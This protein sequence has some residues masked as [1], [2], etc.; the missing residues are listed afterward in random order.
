MKNSTKTRIAVSFGLSFIGVLLVY[1]W[2][3][4]PIKQDRLLFMPGSQQGTVNLESATRCDN[5]HGGYNKAVEPAHNWRGGMMAQAARD[6]MWAAC[7]TVALQ[8]S[9]WAL[10]NPNAGDLCIRCHTPTGWLAGHSDPPNLTALAGSDFEGVSCDA[11]HKMVDPFRGL[12][13]TRDVPAETAGTTAASEAL[14]TYTQDYNV[15]AVLQLF[16]ATL[17]F[18]AGTDLPRYYGD[19][20]LPNYIESASGQYFIDASTPKRGPRW[21]AD[22]K[23]QWYY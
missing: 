20:A 22:P 18:N 9:I 11:C 23:H 14:K 4:L 8:D 17:F 3:P 10:G 19:G 12:K 7:L 1:G 16:D 6:P 15:L 21:D 13:Q 5:C 2:T